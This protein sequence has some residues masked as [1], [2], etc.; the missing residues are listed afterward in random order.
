MRRV[1]SVAGI[2]SIAKAGGEPRV[3]ISV[4]AATYATATSTTALSLALPAGAAEHDTLLAIIF[5]ATVNININPPNALPLTWKGIFAQNNRINTLNVF[6]NRVPASPP[7]T[8]AFTTSSS[9]ARYGFLVALRGDVSGIQ[10]DDITYDSVTT[11]T[12]VTMQNIKA[13]KPGLLLMPTMVAANVAIP[14]I[15]G[16][17]LIASNATT[18]KTALFAQPNVKDDDALQKLVEWA[19]ASTQKTAAGLLVT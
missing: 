6:A 10:V 1:R 11:G 14:T 18:P 17:T 5:G 3:P 13:S 9:N 7:A 19:S 15:A 2:E 16:M 4:V 12:S 8:Y